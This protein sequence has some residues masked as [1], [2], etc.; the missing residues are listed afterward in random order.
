MVEWVTAL[1]GGLGLIG[2]AWLMFL[3]NV[4]PPIPSELIMPLAGFTAATGQHD[5]W[6]VILAG[7]LGSVAGAVMWYWVGRRVGSDRMRRLAARHGR[8]LTLSP[9]DIT[10]AED[11]F[12]RHGAI[13]VLLGRLV[14]AVR[15]LISVPAG[16]AR[17][18][19]GSFLIWTS[20]GT[21]V[22]SGLLAV[23]GYA[24]RSS[25]TDVGKWMDP[26]ATAVLVGMLGW[27]LWRVITW[28]S[29]GSQDR[30]DPKA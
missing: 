6:A 22:W 19:Q 30:P 15:T 28:P 25:Y 11:W 9:Q 26:L 3:E 5:L 10:R 7:T 21:A 1:V 4:F 8:W 18:S 16:A 14:P 2:I 23:A 20:L 27:Y 29:H 24:L 12:H 13:A 17:M